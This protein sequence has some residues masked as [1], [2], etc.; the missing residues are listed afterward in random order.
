MGAWLLPERLVAFVARHRWSLPLASLAAVCFATLAS[1]VREQELGP[2][3]SAL[4]GLVANL[5]GQLD[6]PMLWLTR[7][8][9][10]ASLT[11]VTLGTAGLLLAAKRR[12]E[13]A[14]VV[15]VGVGI[16]LL[17]GALKLFFHRQRPEASALYL[18]QTPL[19]FSFP[20]GHAFGSTAVLFGLLIVARVSGVRGWRFRGLCLL[21]L[22]VA[23]GVCVSR[24]YFGVHFPSDVLGG[25]LGGAGWVSALTGFFYPAALQG[26][27]A[28]PGVQV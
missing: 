7:F 21:G 9:N 2:F 5:R 26:E 14:F 10:G 22:L 23:V 16:V 13:S 17:V 4:A 28:E 6:Q 1:E 25:M 12:R 24:V 3:D 8:G 19:S 27:H 18:L 20:S 15:T 11:T